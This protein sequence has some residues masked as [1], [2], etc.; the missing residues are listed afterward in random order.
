MR[1]PGR[2]EGAPESRGPPTLGRWGG[3]FAV[4]R[5]GSLWVC[6]PAFSRRVWNQGRFPGPSPGFL[7]LLR[8]PFDVILPHSGAWPPGGL[9]G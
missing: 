9:T 4:G 2:A 6:S 3:P 8:P 1:R 5:P 7:Q